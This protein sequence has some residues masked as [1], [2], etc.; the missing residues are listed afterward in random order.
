MKNLN[1]R[2]SIIM[3]FLMLGTKLWS[4]PT[5][6]SLQASNVSFSA[7]NNTFGTIY[8]TRGNGDA[9]VVFVKPMQVLESALPGNGTDYIA[10]TQFGNGTQ[11]SSTGWYA[12]YKGTGTNVTV[13]GLTPGTNYRVHVVERNFNG[14][15]D[16]I[17]YLHSNGSQ[18]P[19]SFFTT[20]EDKAMYF[21]GYN[22]H[23][24]VSPDSVQHIGKKDF[25]L[26]AWVRPFDSTGSNYVIMSNQLTSGDENYFTLFL[27]YGK[28]KAIFNIPGGS[29]PDVTLSTNVNI[30]DDRWHHVAVMREGTNFYL[31]IDG[32]QTE[33]QTMTDTLDLSNTQTGAK[34]TIGA[35]YFGSAT[36]FFYGY[37][38]EVRMWSKLVESDSL[39]LNRY[40]KLSPGTPDLRLYIP[41]DNIGTDPFVES[42]G[43][44]FSCDLINLTVTGQ[45]YT[46]HAFTSVYGLWA[47]D[48][49][50]KKFTAVWDSIPGK[51]YEIH[52]DTEPYFYY[53]YEQ[54]STSNSQYRLEYNLNPN[55]QYYIRVITTDGTFYSNTFA[56]KTK[57]PLVYDFDGN[58][59]ETVVIGEQT[60]MAQ[61]FRGKHYSDG[62][63]ISHRVWEDQDYNAEN[64]GRLYTWRNALDNNIQVKSQG[65]CPTGW[66]V[67]SVSEW[68]SLFNFVGHPA[69]GK[70]KSIAPLNYWAAPNTSA[71]DEYGFSAIGSGRYSGAYYGINFFAHYQTS[72][73]FNSGYAYNTN[74][75]YND[76]TAEINAVDTSFFFAVRCIKDFCPKPNVNLGPDTFGILSP[77]YTLIAPA[78]QP[79]DVGQWY[80]LTNETSYGYFSDETNDTTT[81]TYESQ[82][83]L[84]RK[85][86][87]R[88]SA[89][90][91]CGKSNYDIIQVGFS[92]DQAL[93]DNMLSAF[94]P[95]NG[96]VNDY[97]T[98]GNNG[99]AY[100]GSYFNFSDTSDKAFVFGYQDTIELSN[101]SALSMSQYS[102]R[103]ISL[104]F[105]ADSIPN[106]RLAPLLSRNGDF[107]IGLRNSK[108]WVYGTG[109]DSLS[110]NTN[111][112]TNTWY[113]LVLL[114]DSGAGK[115]KIYLNKNLD[116]AGKLTYS[117]TQSEDY[118]V[119][120]IDYSNPNRYFRGKMDNIGFWDRHLNKNEIDSLY[121]K[122][123]PVK[124][125]PAQLSVDFSSNTKNIELYVQNIHDY[126]DG[127]LIYRSDDGGSTY[128]RIDSLRSD[129]LESYYPIKEDTIQLRKEY[130][131][132]LVSFN[133]FGKTKSNVVRIIAAAPFS[134]N[135]LALNSVDGYLRINDHSKLDFNASTQ[136]YTLEAWFKANE[137][138][139]LAGIISKSHDKVITGYA[140]KLGASGTN[141]YF[142]GV[143][144]PHGS[145]K[146]DQWYHVAAVSLNNTKTIYINGRKQ[147]LSGTPYNVTPNSEFLAIGWDSIQTENRLFKGEIDEV[148]IWSIARDSNQIRNDMHK[149][150]DGGFS[151]LELLLDMDNVQG[152]QYSDT[153]Y[154]ISSNKL[155]A[156]L[157]NQTSYA[158]FNQSDALY[159]PLLQSVGN[160][161][162]TSVQ[163]KW[164]G[165][166]IG[167]NYIEYNTDSIELMYNSQN[168]EWMGNKFIY[169]LDSLMTDSTYFVRLYFFDEYADR[170]FLGEIF[171]IKI[172]NCL[173]P[174]ANAGPDQLD[175][176]SP[177]IQLA[178]NF[179]GNVTRM[180]YNLD[181]ATNLGTFDRRDIENTQ[182]T[183]L[184][185]K[186]Y[187]LLW[188]LSNKCGSSQDTLNVSFKKQE[189]VCM[190]NFTY[191]VNS[192]I[193]QATFTNNSSSA[194]KYYWDFGDGS[195]A[196]GRN[197]VHNYAKPGLYLVNL[198]ISD[199]AGKCFDFAKE[200]IQVGD[201][202]CKASYNYVVDGLKVD[203][204]NSSIGNPD[205]LFWTFDD[206]NSSV[207]A[208]PSHTFSEEG[209]YNIGLTVSASNGLCIDYYEQEVQVG[210]FDCHASFS[211]F[212]DSAN[213]K[214]RF[215]N[216][217]TGNNTFS[218]WSFGDGTISTQREPV[219]V[220][221][222]EGYYVASMSTF[223]PKNS[224]MDYYEETILVGSSA[225]DCEAG[226]IYQI[227]NRTVKFTD[228]S[229]GDIVKYLWN[230]GDNTTPSFETSPNHTYTRDG[231]FNV[232]LLVE[233][234]NGISNITC[235]KVIVRTATD[236]PCDANFVF[237]VDSLTKKVR[238]RD[239]SL[240]KPNQWA[241]DFGNGI[242][243][244]KKIDSL[245]YATKGYYLV[246]LTI[247][248]TT[249]GCQDR[250]Y[251]L[252]NVAEANILKA[253]FG[254]DPKG[255]SQKAGGYPVDF[256][257]TGIG[258]HAKLRWDFGDQTTDT[259]SD[260]QTHTY[261]QPG[262]YSVCYTV[263]DPVTGESDQAC[264][265]VVIVGE[266]NT[267]VKENQ[268]ISQVKTIPN[269]F[270]HS[271][272]IEYS[273]SEPSQVSI[274]LLNLQGK[275][276]VKVAAGKMGSGTHQT[277]IG[278]ANIAQGCYILQLKT[279]SDI[280]TKLV[281][282]E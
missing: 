177:Q 103:S 84:Y 18:N 128:S 254:N 268:S 235:N 68:D 279:K 155:K 188:V 206:G 77:S 176:T 248:N 141:I 170:Y 187:R 83:D 51:T 252:V 225:S 249:T 178:A 231:V 116:K 232:C 89:T 262:T 16:S 101:N 11:I 244:T 82:S 45:L 180:W 123:S 169:T 91:A 146:K 57:R 228:R 202:S 199:S 59:Y 96:N 172:P 23:I 221:K 87:I 282:K 156:Y 63:P 130:F 234:T 56:V 108:L 237:S 12:V 212:V 47:K 131:Y 21:A 149:P 118:T 179:P 7:I 73:Y 191:T 40:K 184:Q 97:S 129:V 136:N 277:I 86:S 4:A 39:A 240:G 3:L 243:S 158:S 138:T 154:D 239:L 99:I 164:S 163:I 259:T 122:A 65:V 13:T 224:C 34:L 263:S 256:I 1:V 203:L 104:Y 213:R 100:G 50:D 46:S 222:K 135:S 258:D 167:K 24:V 270:N 61:N 113:H 85:F 217:S 69:G 236:E 25:T 143:Q 281:T 157:I 28:P 10:N 271:L 274:S 80:N 147:A 152:G 220:Y 70:L 132:Y 241:W 173:S 142:D 30:G 153:V 218:M 58:G 214:V 137:L 31:F 114:M 112:S 208:N 266:T 115:T 171:K 165:S 20:N 159:T 216:K 182:F 195:I 15:V 253:A 229:K 189:P 145:I 43:N 54:I 197:S 33:E 74:F 102:K 242:Q 55:T 126:D 227:E 106:N 194:Y 250:T 247:K 251:K 238:F 64:L 148:R 161:T 72:N 267:T 280:T 211:Y 35:K 75:Y 226:Y 185:G 81:L 41:F 207:L 269:P 261:S 107:A 245:V 98:F 134:G 257:G 5:P 67:P 223:N 174:I 6:P 93:L 29:N 166:F 181:S 210:S 168:H 26:E 71:T 193:N 275:V 49:T 215:I 127:Y 198:A 36:G 192:T 278:T 2:I 44:N 124:P 255:F 140:L 27:E 38:D 22:E 109:S 150:I 66:H 62:R 125:L 9:C 276:V 133:E 19:E 79:G 162:P 53:P 246:G 121:H 52:I 60:W 92:S 265:D 230:F 37:I 42:S 139:P 272:S 264:N 183:G 48:V 144:T 88:W 190:A 78:L 260:M 105:N 119:A 90:N 111:I 120:G 186:T 219:H 175:V 8:W 151:N 205:K 201:V 32:R 196:T 95:L 200:L 94:Y 76:D 14:S 17:M 204:T 273:I 110:S 209:I 233:N 117:S 160:F